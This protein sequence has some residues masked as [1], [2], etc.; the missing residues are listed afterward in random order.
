LSR[1]HVDLTKLLARTISD[2]DDVVALLFTRPTE[3]YFDP[4][5]TAMST[6]FLGI[7]EWN[8][9]SLDVSLLEFADAHV[10]VAIVPN[11][12]D[13]VVVTYR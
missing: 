12:L 11:D 7:W 2:K 3:G 9:V 4:A 5:C 6:G 10:F 13:L 1:L 8:V